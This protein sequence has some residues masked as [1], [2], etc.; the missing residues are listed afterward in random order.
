MSCLGVI[1]SVVLDHMDFLSE[2]S[3]GSLPTF[4]GRVVC[5]LAAFLLTSFENESLRLFISHINA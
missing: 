5:S 2:F 1:S 4:H 3:Y